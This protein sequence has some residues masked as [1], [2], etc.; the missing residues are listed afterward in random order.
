MSE[1]ISE[2]R[3]TLAEHAPQVLQTQIAP[4]QIGLLIGKGGET[5]RGLQDEYEVQIDVE[6]D[7]SVRI[8][9]V[10]DLAI[11]AREHVEQMMRP[12][13]VGDVYREK[14]VVKTADFGAFVE[15]RKGTDGL[16]HV[17]R[18]AP[19]VRIDSADQVLQRNDVVSVEVTEVDADRGR[20]A[21]KLVSK[22]EDGVEVTPAEIGE[23]YKEQFP[24]AGQRSDR[25]QG[26][27]EGGDGDRDRRRRRGP[28]GGGGGGPRLAPAERR[29]RSDAARADDAPLRAAR[30][31]GADAGRALGGD[32]CLGRGG[33]ARRARPGRRHLAL[34][35]APAVPR[36]GPALGAR[37]RADLRPLR[38]RA[39]RRH[40][41]RDDVD[42]R[43]RHRRPPAARPWTSSAAWS[44]SPSWDDLE[45]EREVVLEEIAMLEDT[46]D[47]LV[48]D[49]IGETDVPRAGAGPADHRHRGGASS[50]SPATT[51]PSTMRRTTS[52]ATSWSPRRGRS[53]TPA[54]WS[55][56][57]SGRWRPPRRSRRREPALAAAGERAF[58]E[59][60]TEQYHVCLAAPG[61]TRHDE[62]RFALALLDQILGSGAS[63]RLFQEIRERRGMAY[64]VYS[65]AAHYG[66]S[67]VVGVYLGTR[68]ENVAECLEVV[69]REIGELAAGR[70]DEDELQRAKD[71]MT[72]RLA[73]AM[74]STGARMNRLGKALVTNGELLDEAEV[75][76]RGSSA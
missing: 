9:G 47:E 43:P 31:H 20:I 34:H 30:G 64:A 51:S 6:E 12:V 38:G 32:R 60:D 27:R 7:G 10:G 26:D 8:Y 3:T 18:V 70:F 29:R 72:G 67:G 42:L 57:R 55:S 22:H 53:T 4:D 28:R 58:I 1:T 11:A 76:A 23:R 41:A 74:E 44:T 35:R 17:S 36:H 65:Y 54:S 39:E 15:L 33:L 56:S 73:L 16:L 69:G 48:F 63:S 21:L 2:P 71:S 62:R 25:P 61:L 49:L 19:G 40:G 59:R 66:D 13:Q 75:G 24:N 37:D 68:G 5:I 52:R 50:G 46:P 45:Q 14:R